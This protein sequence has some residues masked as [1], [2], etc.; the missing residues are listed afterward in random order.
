[1]RELIKFN[2]RQSAE[3]LHNILFVNRIENHFVDDDN[4][5]VVW[6]HDED[7]MQQ[8][9]ELLADYKYGRFDQQLNDFSSSVNKTK[10]RIKKEQKKENKMFKDRSQI[11][12]SNSITSMGSATKILIF[13][14]IAAFLLNWLKIPIYQL[15]FISSIPYILP[16]DSPYFLYEVVH[17]QIWRIITP[18]FMHF[19]IFH[20]IFNLWWL[21]DLGTAIEITQGTKHYLLIVG[22]IAIFSNLTEYII[23]IPSFQLSLKGNFGGMS[24]VIFGLLGYIYMRGK[25]NSSSGLFLDQTTLYIM[26]GYLVVTMLFFHGLAHAAH[27]GGLVSGVALGYIY[28]NKK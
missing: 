20:I 13:I 28:R 12:R 3:N 21:K 1:M 15:F 25:L 10:T 4:K 2:D 22:I 9:E 18:I 14:S 24:G 17:G 27:V 7:Q 23:D 19:G 16:V 5:W 8:S 11:F 26:I 6:I